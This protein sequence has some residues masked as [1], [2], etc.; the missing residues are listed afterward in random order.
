MCDN[1]E[2]YANALLLNG[3]IR[4]K[5]QPKWELSSLFFLQ[6]NLSTST[7]LP[8]LWVLLTDCFFLEPANWF[9]KPELLLRGPQDGDYVSGWHLQRNTEK[10]IF[11]V[12]IVF[13]AHWST[14]PFFPRTTQPI[15][16]AR[17]SARPLNLWLQSR[18]GALAIFYSFKPACN[19]HS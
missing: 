19:W 7:N 16:E 12:S 5:G 14:F 15:L 13:S 1:R 18:L 10:M 9:Y 2:G 11:V 8:F 6:L 4:L 3:I 17:T